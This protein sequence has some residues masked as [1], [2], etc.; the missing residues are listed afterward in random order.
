MLSMV[1]YALALLVALAPALIAAGAVGWPLRRFIGEWAWLP[2]GLVGLAV[3][4]G[5]SW[6]LLRPL[7]R[8]FE[9]I[10]IPTAGIEAA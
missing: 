3:L 1:V 5:E 9:R 6:L 10:D 7:G 2:G 4:A 8:A